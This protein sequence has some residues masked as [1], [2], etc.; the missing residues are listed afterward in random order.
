MVS[1]TRNVMIGLGSV[2]F[3][4]VAFALYFYGDTAQGAAQSSPATDSSAVMTLSG[5]IYGDFNFDCEVTALD[6]AQVAARWGALPGDPDYGFSYDLDLSV[7][8]EFYTSVPDGDID[9]LD[10]QLV[11]S[12]WAQTC[13][14]PLTFASPTSPDSPP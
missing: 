6:I 1:R 8:G 13:E 2:A 3:V 4:A 14:S 9:F 5:S 11:A 7:P 10:I 12:R